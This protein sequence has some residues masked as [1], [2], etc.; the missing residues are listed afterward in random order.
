MI[1]AFSLF[2]LSLCS[3]ERLIWEENKTLLFPANTRE[4]TGSPT[5]PGG[6]DIYRRLF[7]HIF[8]PCPYWRILRFK[9]WWAPAQPRETPPHEGSSS[10]STTSSCWLFYYQSPTT[11]K[12]L[13][14]TAPL[15]YSH[16]M[17][18]KND[19]YCTPNQQGRKSN[20]KRSSF[21][22]RDMQIGRDI[23]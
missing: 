10:P 14:R 5:Q 8:H 20:A 13:A 15:N 23:L 4:S 16:R 12:A 22:W 2:S 7:L 19:F 21:S 3:E 18:K 11:L 1:F 9:C 6:M 17:Q